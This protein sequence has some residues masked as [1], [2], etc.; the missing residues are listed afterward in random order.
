MF[1]HHFGKVFWRLRSQS[2]FTL[3]VFFST[4]NFSVARPSS[5]TYRRRMIHRMTSKRWMERKCS[6]KSSR[7]G[8]AAMMFAKKT[9]S[10]LIMLHRGAFKL[11]VELMLTCFLVFKLFM[12][13]LQKQISFESAARWNHLTLKPTRYWSSLTSSECFMHTDCVNGDHKWRLLMCRKWSAI[14]LARFKYVKSFEV[15]SEP[16]IKSSTHIHFINFNFLT[17]NSLFQ[18]FYEQM[19]SIQ[20]QSFTNTSYLH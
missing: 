13:I 20:A 1:N 5:S 11:L 2:L 6:T 3:S 9:N 16:V 15:L 18:F 4:K 7:V 17:S 12:I 8:T 14:K 19:N 10:N